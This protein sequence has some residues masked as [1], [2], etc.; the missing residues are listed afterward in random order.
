MATKTRRELID[1]VLGNLH[2]LAL[3][4]VPDDEMVSKV[5]GVIDG[6]AAIL[7]QDGVTYF[8]DLGL[9]GPSGGAIELWQFLPLADFVANQAGPQFHLAG[10]PQLFTLAE[11]AKDLLKTL[12]RPARVRRELRVDPALACIGRRWR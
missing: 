8:N 12:G 11:R 3:G 1:Q 9:A 7:E 10:D 5:D 4:Q 2:V 6:A